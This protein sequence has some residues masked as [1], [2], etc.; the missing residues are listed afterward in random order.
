MTG[1][2]RRY[3]QLTQILLS[4]YEPKDRTVLRLQRLNELCAG[5]LDSLSAGEM[6]RL[7]PGE[8]QARESDK[9]HYR[10]P[11]TR[12]PHLGLPCPSPGPFLDMS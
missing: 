4:K 5:Q 3:D 9:L 1:T 6:R 12:R 10:Y 11:G 7:F 2:L 8:Y